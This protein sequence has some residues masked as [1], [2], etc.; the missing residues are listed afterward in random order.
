MLPI[1]ELRDRASLPSVSGPSG[2]ASAET[3]LSGGEKVGHRARHAGVPWPAAM[4]LPCVLNR[5][6][7][8][9]AQEHLEFR[10]PVSPRRPPPLRMAVG[11]AVRVGVRV[12]AVG[13]PERAGVRGVRWSRTARISGSAAPGTGTSSAE[14]V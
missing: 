1:E 4:A 11:G 8:L 9:M 14:G 7:L 13:A 10:L 5:Y 3:V 6:L 2:S 12:E